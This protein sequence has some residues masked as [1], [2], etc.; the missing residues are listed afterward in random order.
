MSKL[1]G[2]QDTSARRH[3]IL[4]G[5]QKTPIQDIVDMVEEADYQ[6]LDKARRLQARRWRKLRSIED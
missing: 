1:I 6:W 2:L 3:Y 4:T 5:S